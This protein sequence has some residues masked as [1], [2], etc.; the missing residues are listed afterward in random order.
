MLQHQRSG[1]PGGPLQQLAILLQ[2]VL[3]APNNTFKWMQ[4]LIIKTRTEAKGV[5]PSKGD[6]QTSSV[7]HTKRTDECHLITIGLNLCLLQTISPL[8]SGGFDVTYTTYQHCLS[9]YHH[10][11]NQGNYK[12]CCTVDIKGISSTEYMQIK[13]RKWCN[14]HNDLFS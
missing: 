6:W 13:Q 8:I 5:K 9:S 4:S 10:R 14:N 12:A 11:L 2:I 7:T 3:L 1:I